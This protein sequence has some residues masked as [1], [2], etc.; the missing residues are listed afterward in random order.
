MSIEIT[1]A[2]GHRGTVSVNADAHPVCPCGET[3]VTH[4]K[5]RAPVFRGVATGPYCETK[6]M[7]PGIVNVA[8]GGSLPLK[9]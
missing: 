7:D 1:F 8:P 4:T 2:C 3:R 9:G 5:A 6:A